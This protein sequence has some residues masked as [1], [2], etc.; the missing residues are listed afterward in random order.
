VLDAALIGC[1]QKIEH[2]EI[3]GYGT[4][5]Y[6][7]EELGLTQ[8]AQLLRQTLEEEQKTDTILNN[9][10]KNKINRRAEGAL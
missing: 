4:A 1:A 9:L 10:A 5:A 6:L 2:Y 3:A 7:A 8:V